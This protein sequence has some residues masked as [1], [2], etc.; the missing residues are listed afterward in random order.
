MSVKQTQMHVTPMQT[1]PTLLA[2]IHVSVLQA[3]KGMVL[4]AIVRVRVILF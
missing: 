3:M 1:V 2:A 4:Q